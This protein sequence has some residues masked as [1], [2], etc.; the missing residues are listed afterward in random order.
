[1]SRTG[2]TQRHFRSKTKTANLPDFLSNCEA[3][4]AAEQERNKAR[5]ERQEQIATATRERE[6]RDLRLKVTQQGWWQRNVDHAARNAVAIQQRQ[7]LV[8]DL[9]R[10]IN[11]LPPP[12]AEP[13]ETYIEQ[14]D[15]SPHLGP[16]YNPKLAGQGVL[17]WW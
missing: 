14:S 3:T 1:G 12:P 6:L 17:R 9:E 16:D 5:R 15:G 11:P 7:A 4:I 8:A 2:P 10:M 13:E